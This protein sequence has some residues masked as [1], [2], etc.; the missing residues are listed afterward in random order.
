MTSES[1]SLPPQRYESRAG[2]NERHEVGREAGREGGKKGGR[3]IRRKG[4]K[5]RGKQNR[6]N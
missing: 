4:Q 2:K 6:V 3:E 1:C 5:T